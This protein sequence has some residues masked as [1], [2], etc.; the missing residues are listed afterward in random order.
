MPKAYI[1]NM[2]AGIVCF[3]GFVINLMSH[4]Y[5]WASIDIVLSIANIFLFFKLR[6][7]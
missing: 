1:L 7:K 6:P 3:L 2:V 5:W 4:F